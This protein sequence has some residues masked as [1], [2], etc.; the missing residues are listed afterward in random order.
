MFVNTGTS[1]PTTPGA[2]APDPSLVTTA[3]T[4]AVLLTH[5][6]PHGAGPDGVADAFAMT[7]AWVLGPTV[8]ATVPALLL[9]GRTPTPKGD[10][11]ES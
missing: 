11:H 7:F 6:S 8:P 9:P 10:D 5:A 3:L 1:R 2:A 4:L